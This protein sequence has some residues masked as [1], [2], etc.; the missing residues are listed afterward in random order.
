M[1]VPEENEDVSSEDKEIRSCVDAIIETLDSPP[2]VYV[3]MD[4]FDTGIQESP[5]E[6]AIKRTK[7]IDEDA[8]KRSNFQGM[9]S[10]DLEA[11]LF[12]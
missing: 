8:M 5:E 2:Q 6:P 12:A 11:L 7:Y 3:E 9:D 10:L 1:D 4:L